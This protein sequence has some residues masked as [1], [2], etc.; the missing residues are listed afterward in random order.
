VL[1][2]HPTE[3]VHES[4]KVRVER[5]HPVDG[6]GFR[7]RLRERDTELGHGVSVSG[8]LVRYGMHATGETGTQRFDGTLHREHATAAQGEERAAGVIH[9]SH[10]ADLLLRQAPLARWCATVMGFPRHPERRGAGVVALER[11]TEVRLV[12]LDFRTA[13]G[14]EHGRVATDALDEPPTHE[15]RRLEA[16]VAPCRTRPQAQ[17]IHEALDEPKPHGWL[18]L[19]GGHDP[20]RPRIERAITIHAQPALGAVPAVSFPPD[21]DRTATDARLGVL[22]LTERHSRTNPRTARHAGR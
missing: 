7:I 1:R 10:H 14:M 8:R 9:A 16:H 13:F 20:A 15:E 18:E 2:A 21:V 11:F 22:W 4:R 3:P 6:M 19:R 5:V 17:A 12:Q